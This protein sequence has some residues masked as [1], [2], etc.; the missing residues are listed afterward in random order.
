MITA[1]RLR[2]AIALALVSTVLAACGGGSGGALPGYGS[3]NTTPT[4]SSDQAPN[5]A[6]SAAATN[7]NGTGG[8]DY[9]APLST[10]HTTDPNAT[11]KGNTVGPA[12]QNAATPSTTN[13]D[14]QRYTIVPDKSKA[15]YHARQKAFVPGIGS[16]IDGS[17]SDIS[18]T[19]FFDP[20]N[21]SRTE[22]AT[23]T[24]NVETLDSG[25]DLRDQRLHGE[26]LESSKFPTATFNATR[27][28]GLPSTPYADGD[29]LSFK[30]AGN[31]TLHGVTRAVTFDATGN[32][33]GDTLTS[34]AKTNVMLTDFGMQV[35]DLLNFVKAE[36]AVGIELSLSAQRS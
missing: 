25:I 27:L 19:I 35:P 21:P 6:S 2:I 4:T 29:E 9:G 13:P 7:S 33:T 28:E 5:A 12:N 26:F 8:Y 23:I 20:R 14:A 3:S 1:F 31:L 34:T 36:N 32:V 18:G 11:G 16:G 22:I 17:T 24:V 10:P 30:I 15:T